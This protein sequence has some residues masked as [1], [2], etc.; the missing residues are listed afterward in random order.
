M[1]GRVTTLYRMAAWGS[2]PLGTLGGGVLASHVGVRTV[3]IVA[4]V[5]IVALTALVS[6]L[7]RASIEAP[8]PERRGAL[9][10]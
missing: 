2:L 7:P 9:D 5:M 10:R 8:R 3:I 4:G 1:L 6:Q